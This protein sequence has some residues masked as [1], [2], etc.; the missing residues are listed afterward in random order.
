MDYYNKLYLVF[1]KSFKQDA[2]LTD[3][4][5]AGNINAIEQNKSALL[6]YAEAGLQSLE[7]MEA[8]ESDLTLVTACKKLL[9]FYQEMCNQKVQPITD[10]VLLSENMKK[11][12]KTLDATPAARRTQADIDSYNKSVKEINDAL[13]AFNKTNNELNRDRTALI[14]GWNSAVDKFLDRH[15]P[16]SK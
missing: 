5:N 6:K 15:I 13:T 4:I 7:A 10:F 9:L 16:Y 3:A 2:Y 8:F 12:K 14:N 11:M 1:F